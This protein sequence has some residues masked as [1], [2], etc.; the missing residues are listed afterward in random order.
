MGV[1]PTPAI[2]HMAESLSIDGY[3][4]GVLTHGQDGILCLNLQGEVV[5]WNPAAERLFGY[6]QAEAVGRRMEFV[7]P[8]SSR[9]EFT[10]MLEAARVGD[11][12]VRRGLACRRAD[13][14]L[15]EVEMTLAAARDQGREIGMVALVRDNSERKRLED[16]LRHSEKL[17]ATGRL[18]ASIAHEINNP[19]ESVSN[20]LYLLQNQCPLDERTRQYVDMAGEEVAH[21]VHITR[22]ALGFYRESA[23]PVSL[24]ISDLLENVL[25]LYAPRIHARRIRVERH[26]ELQPEIRG[27]PGE[28]RRVFS[29]LIVNALEAVGEDGEVRL[30]VFESRDWHQPEQHGVRVVIADNGPGIPPEHRQHIFEPFYTTKGE[31]GTGLGLWLSAGIIHKYGGDIR[32]RSSARPGRH[33]TVFSIFLPAQ[34]R[35]QATQAA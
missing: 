26:F 1:Q 19:L 17:A 15:V 33:A 2:S 14:S 10:A 22:Q 12:P 24:R 27:F 4:A 20:L 23:A 30:H 6:S 7:V 34:P 3:L 21:I 29:N 16:A 9:S 5:I 25:E 18:A 13:G 35:E 8:P 28:M 31:S 11:R 32:M